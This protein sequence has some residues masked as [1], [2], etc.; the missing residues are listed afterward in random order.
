MIHTSPAEDEADWEAVVARFAPEGMKDLSMEDLQKY[1]KNMQEL[2]YDE[3]E[4]STEVEAYLA[5]ITKDCTSPYER[6]QAIERE[7]AGYAYNTN[8]G[9]LPQKV[10]SQE[11]F[12]DYFL[13]ESKQGYCTYFATAF[14]LLARAEGFPARY[15]EGFCVPLN[16]SKEMHVTSGM[17]HAWPEVYIEGIGWLPFEP[18][19]GYTNLRYQGWK[20]KKPQTDLDGEGVKNTPAPTPPAI[21]QEVIEQ[22]DTKRKNAEGWYTLLKVICVVL[23]VCLVL[24]FVEKMRQKRVYK[25]L[26][27]EQKYVIEV[28]QNLWL[29]EKIGYKRAD[30]ETLSELQDIISKELPEVFATKQDRYFLTGY[31][32]YLYGEEEV[33]EQ[34]LQS[35]IA[36][37]EDMLIWLKKENKRYYYFIKFLMFALR[38]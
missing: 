37:R 17:A 12:L 29:L 13:L 27:V 36:K 20:V 9:K 28:K 31:E 26:S 15:V 30:S 18:T 11:E 16:Q 10:K 8:P 24:F 5:E 3:I 35:A 1:R 22:E 4:I 7:L 2:Y 6:L 25:K 23:P 14:V 32:K 38:Y 33:S 21:Q 34:L 19:P